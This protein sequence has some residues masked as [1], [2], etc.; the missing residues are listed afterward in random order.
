MDPPKL[1]PPGTTVLI[2]KKGPPGTYFTAKYGPPSDK[3]GPPSTD[4]KIIDLNI[5]VTSKFGPEAYLEITQ[6]H[7]FSS[8]QC[9]VASFSHTAFIPP[10]ISQFL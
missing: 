1:V 8:T 2:K 4:E 7:E 9:T 10:Y 5:S 6:V 3:L